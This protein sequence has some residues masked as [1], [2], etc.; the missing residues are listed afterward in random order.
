MNKLTSL[1]NVLALA[2]IAG[3]GSMGVG[4]ASPP[5]RDWCVRCQ[6]R[7]KHSALV[8]S[9]TGARYCHRC[10]YFESKDKP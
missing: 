1:Q 2:A 4:G 10:G 3:A 9:V 8:K 6:G 5:A 7:G